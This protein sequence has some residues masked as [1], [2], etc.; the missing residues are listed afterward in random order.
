MA[1]PNTTDHRPRVVPPGFVF[2]PS[3]SSAAATPRLVP[4]RGRVLRNVLKV[5][6]SPLLCFKERSPSRKS[7]A[8]RN[9]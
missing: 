2:H 1:A 6:F 9:S 7:A 3:S 5:L 8:V 4:R